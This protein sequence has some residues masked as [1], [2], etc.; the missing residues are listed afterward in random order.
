MDLKVSKYVLRQLALT[1][2][3]YRIDLSE[4]DCAEIRSVELLIECINRGE[5][6]NFIFIPPDRFPIAEVW[7]LLALVDVEIWDGKINR[8]RLGSRVTSE[9]IMSWFRAWFRVHKAADDIV[10]DQWLHL[11]YP[12]YALRH[13][14]AFATATRWATYHSSSEAR[15]AHINFLPQLRIHPSVGDFKLC[16]RSDVL[17]EKISRS[18]KFVEDRVLKARIRGH[19][20]MLNQQFAEPQLERTRA[21]LLFGLAGAAEPV[22]S[23]HPPAKA[24]STITLMYGGIPGGYIDPCL[25]CEILTSMNE[26]YFGGLNLEFEPMYTGS[27]WI[28]PR[29]PLGLCHNHRLMFARQAP[30][31]HAEFART[32]GYR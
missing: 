13:E 4:Q 7:R 27:N 14:E 20:T 1:T 9:C 32:W 31:A 29:Q 11:V 25:I 16:Y 3:P 10:G 19:L 24:V 21:G 12:A 15:A 18:L 26:E 28:T 23:N 2:P 6:H 30:G 22:I 5:N 8:G 17:D